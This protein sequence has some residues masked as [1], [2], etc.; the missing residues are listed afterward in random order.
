VTKQDIS[1]ARKLDAWSMQED[2][3][4]QA[5]QKMFNPP[6]VHGIAVPD[7]NDQPAR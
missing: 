2:D 7:T 3:Q 4:D 6:L 5:Q 1:K